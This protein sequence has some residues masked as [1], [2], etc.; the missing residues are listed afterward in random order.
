M[1]WNLNAVLICISFMDKDVEYLQKPAFSDTSLATP[2][3]F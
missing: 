1:R 2:A 3:Y